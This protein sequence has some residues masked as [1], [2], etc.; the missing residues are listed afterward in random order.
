MA[1]KFPTLEFLVVS[2]A[3]EFACKGRF[4]DGSGNFDCGEPTPELYELVY[5][6]PMPSEMLE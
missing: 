4:L 3:S 5:D 6:E 1:E 2:W